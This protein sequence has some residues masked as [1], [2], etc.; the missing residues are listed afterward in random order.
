MQLSQL[1][2][3]YIDYIAQI[4]VILFGGYMAVKGTISVR[5]FLY[6]LFLFRDD[7]ISIT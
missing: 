2:Y 7:D 3:G 6:V 5:N 1:I 4:G